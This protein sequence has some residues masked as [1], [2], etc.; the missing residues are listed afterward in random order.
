[1]HHVEIAL[2]LRKQVKFSYDCEVYVLLVNERAAVP[3]WVE[4]KYVPYDA[5]RRRGHACCSAATTQC[6]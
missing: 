5:G 3:P 4:S 2:C 1:M 6:T